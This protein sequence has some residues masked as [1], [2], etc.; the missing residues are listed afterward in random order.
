LA[1]HYSSGFGK[2]FDKEN[3]MMLGECK[4]DLVETDSTKYT[5][6]KW[7]GEF[8]TKDRIQ[9]AGRY[10]I[11]FDD[12]RCGTCMVTPNSDIGQR[13]TDSVYYYRFFGRG[14]LAKGRT[15]GI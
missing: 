9:R 8:S 6:K 3:N 4:F 11:E 13:K 1:I 5:N 2:L 10:L 14:R 15:E 7:W 12:K